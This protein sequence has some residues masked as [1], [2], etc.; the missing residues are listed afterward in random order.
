MCRSIFDLQKLPLGSAD[1]VAKK[2]KKK[3]KE[4]GEMMTG[5]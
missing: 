2:R 3:R 4:K 5:R 1:M